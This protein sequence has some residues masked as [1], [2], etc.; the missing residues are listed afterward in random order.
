VDTRERGETADDS[1]LDGNNAVAASGGEV[2]E[3][4]PTIM[5]ALSNPRTEAALVSVAGVLAKYQGGT[6]LA[7]HVVQVPD[8][9]AL[10]IAAEQRD[11]IDDESGE[12]LAAA[13]QDA[14]AMGVDVETKTVLSHRALEEVFDAARRND[15]D[16]VV[17]GYGGA[18]FAGGRIEGALDEL[19][20]DLPCDVL[21]LND[22][23]YDP[24]KVLLPTAGGYSSTL[25]ATVARALRDT[26][27]AEVSVLYVA[28]D[29]DREAG[30]AFITE[31]VAEHGLS[32]AE[33]L[34]ETGDVER[35]I[36]RAAAD[37]TLVVI[38]ATERG[39]LSRIVRDSLAFS[40]LE[41]L[42]T[43]V[44]L[45]ERPSSRSLRERLVGRR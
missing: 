1:V 16:T 39:L 25:S 24:S 2:H 42:D 43:S 32:D 9:T 30:R 29:G 4:G 6:V 40:V 36:E 3:E 35:A 8:Q 38:G 27:D 45:A 15:A 26:A 13:R 31:W 44:L 20:H 18:R 33:I 19:A 22:R 23:G 5:V 12:L 21:V 7:T 41:D 28:E 17:M 37:R 10:E 14:A 34:V 11:R